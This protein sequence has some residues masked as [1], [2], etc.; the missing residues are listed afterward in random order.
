MNVTK[1]IVTTTL[2]KITELADYAI[3]HMT[4]DDVITRI[5]VVVKEKNTENVIGDIY[6]D[7][8]STGGNFSFLTDVSQYFIEFNTFLTEIRESI[9][10]ART[11]NNQ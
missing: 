11:A 1:T 10:A 5:H 4:E 7:Q 8:N 3:E 6:Q 9:T 2:E